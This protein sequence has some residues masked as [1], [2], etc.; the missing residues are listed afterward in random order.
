MQQLHSQGGAQ[1]IALHAHA[2]VALRVLV[3]WWWGLAQCCCAYIRRGSP[4]LTVLAAYTHDDFAISGWALV[5]G[6]SRHQ[7]PD[8]GIVASTFPDAMGARYMLSMTR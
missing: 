4:G 6:F 1:S 3:L 2:T 5:N 7:A 8:W